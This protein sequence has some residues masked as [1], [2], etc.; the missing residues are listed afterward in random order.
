MVGTGRDI[1]KESDVKLYSYSA[2]PPEQQEKVL[3]GTFISS[4]IY[5]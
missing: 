4:T 1:R 3:S 5:K 2:K